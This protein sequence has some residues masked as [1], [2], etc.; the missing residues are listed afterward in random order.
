MVYQLNPKTQIS[1]GVGVGSIY[2]VSVG[3]SHAINPN[4]SIGFESKVCG[5]MKKA[6][7]VFTLSQK[8][9]NN[10]I[11]QTQAKVG[12]NKNGLTPGSEV[13]LG[14]IQRQDS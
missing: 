12:F 10:L 3:A 1:G 5:H 13:K 7:T 2:G 9:S 14:W 8:L 4:L 6:S 11:F